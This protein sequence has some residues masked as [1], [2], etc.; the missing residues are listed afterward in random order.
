MINRT[1]HKDVKRFLNY[2]RVV[3]QNAAQTI[4]RRRA[5]LRHLLEWADEAPFPRA[6]DIRPAFPIYLRSARNDGR[7]RPLAI[8][9]R[10]ATCGVARRFFRWA[11]R[12]HTR[13]YSS[14]NL[15]WTESLRVASGR[16][17]RTLNDHRLV[18]P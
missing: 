17:T 16:G 3:R 12:E 15:N 9:T 1:N 6:P 11:K 14:V 8:S 10:R 2:L 4:K 18:H 7:D 13:R 5:Q